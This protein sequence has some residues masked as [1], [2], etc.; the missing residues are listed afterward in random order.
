MIKPA[1]PVQFDREFHLKEYDT[2][3][4]EIMSRVDEARSVAQFVIIASGA[5]LVWLITNKSNKSIPDIAFWLPF[6][7]VLLGLIRSLA[8]LTTISRIT[9][10][11]RMIETIICK[12]GPLSGWES[13]V[14]AERNYL[15]DS[16]AVVFWI[17]SL[18]VTSIIPLYLTK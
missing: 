12:D 2:L 9:K 3:R 8:V 18:L 5:I 11:L 14:E 13:F 6:I 16:A 17:V 7:M 15:S 1:H 10:Y 4:N